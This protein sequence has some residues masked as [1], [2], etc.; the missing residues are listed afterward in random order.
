MELQ[1]RTGQPQPPCWCTQAA[2]PTALLDRVPEAARGRAC[3]CA[4]CAEPPAT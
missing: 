2:F 3:V 1:R 4:A